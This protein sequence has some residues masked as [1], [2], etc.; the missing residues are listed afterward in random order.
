MAKYLRKY[1]KETN[2]WEVLSPSSSSDVYVTNPSIVSADTPQNLDSVL[3]NINNDIIKLKRNVS[4]LAEHGGG[5]NGI[6]GGSVASYKFLVTNGG[7]VND[8]LYVSSLPLTIKFKVSG[9]SP[10]DLVSYQVYYDG[11]SLTNGLK[12]VN[13]N[14]EQS[15]VINKFTDGI[16]NHTLRFEGIDANGMSIDTYVLTIIESS[17]KIELANDVFNY[18]INDAGD[19]IVYVTNKIINSDTRLSITNLTHNKTKVFTFKTQDTIKEAFTF[20]LFN[21]NNDDERLLIKNN[22]EVNKKYTFAISATTTTITNTEISSDILYPE[23]WFKSSNAFTIVVKGI[24]SYEDVLNNISV[25]SEHEL[26]SNLSFSFNIYHG[27]LSIAY[28]SIV[29]SKSSG[30]TRMDGDLNIYGDYYANNEEELKNSI[31]GGEPTV[32]STGVSTLIQQKIPNDSSYKGEQFIKIKCWS[33]DFKVSSS[34]IGVIDIVDSNLDIFP[35]QKPFRRVENES[36]YT[37]F[38]DFD[39]F[40]SVESGMPPSDSSSKIWRTVQYNYVGHKLDEYGNTSLQKWSP[41]TILRLVN[42]NG[43][44]SGFVNRGGVKLMR[45]QGESYGYIESPFKGTSGMKLILPHHSFTLS[46]GFKTDIHPTKDMTVFEWCSYG[47]DNNITQGIKITLEEIIWNV[48]SNKSGQSNTSVL[49]VNIQQNTLTCVDFVYNASSS[50]F[51]DK[52]IAKILVNGVVNAAV[53]IGDI[54]CDFVKNNDIYIAAS[55]IDGKIQNHSDVDIYSIRFFT[56]PLNDIDLLINSH[57]TI[58]ERTSEGVINGEKYNSWI[59]K[60]FLYKDKNSGMP[61]SDL[62]DSSGRGYKTTSFN[63]LCN[64]N[65]PLPLVYIDA[66][67]SQ[68]LSEYSFNKDFFFK[69][70][71]DSTITSHTFT[72]CTMYY[73]DKSAKN[74]VVEVNNVAISLQGTSSTI[75]R[76]K[77]LEIYFQE[78]CSSYGDGRVQLFQPKD[79]WFP[80]SQFTLKADVVDSAHA[81]NA[82]LGKWINDLSSNGILEKTVGYEINEKNPPKDKVYVNGQIIDKNEG[83]PNIWPSQTKQKVKNTL[84]GFPILLFIRFKGEQFEE[85]IGIYSFNLGRYS[86]YNLGLKFFKYFSRRKISISDSNKYEDVKCP[87][88]VKYYDFYT[89]EEVIELNNQTFY[90]RQA[91]SFEFGAGADDNTSEHST[92]SQD[93]YSILSNVGSFRYYAASDVPTQSPDPSDLNGWKNLKSL[94]TIT[95]QC[96]PQ[97]KRYTLNGDKYIPELDVNGEHMF[98]PDGQDQGYQKLVKNL[99]IHNSMVYFTVCSIFGMV[100]SLGKN[101]TLRSWNCDPSN[102]DDTVWYPCFYDMD[103][104]LGL[105]N[106]GEEI[107]EYDAYVDWYKNKP[108]VYDEQGKPNDLNTLNISPNYSGNDYQNRYGG[109]N[110]K[111]WRILRKKNESSINLPWDN[112]QANVLGSQFRQRAGYV[113]DYYEEIYS[114]LRSKDGL[115]GDADKFIE[116]FTGQTSECGEIVFNFDYSVKYLTKFASYSGVTSM[117]DIKMLH[118]NRKEYVRNW[119]NN[120]LMFLDGVFEANSYGIS[121]TPIAQVGA[122]TFGGNESISSKPIFNLRVTNPTMLI[123]SVGSTESKRY[124]L[125]PYTDVDIVFPETTSTKQATINSTSIISKF[126]GLKNYRLNKF[127]N[128]TL[129]KLTSIDFSNVQTFY[130]GTPVV[131]HTAFTFDS[132]LKD[133]EGRILYT[134]NVKEI[135]L[136]NAKQVSGGD[137]NDG[138]GTFNIELQT[139][140]ESELGKIYYNFDKVKKIDISN[141]CVSQLTLPSAILEELNIKYSDLTVLKMENQPL[142]SN[143]D[144]TGCKKLEEVYITN[145][146]NIKS[147]S[148]CNLNDLNKVNILSCSE[149]EKLYISGNSKISTIEIDKCNKLTEIVLDKNT[150]NNLEVKILSCNKLIKFSAKN[151]RTS[152]KLILPLEVNELTTFDIYGWQGIQEIQYGSNSAKKY[153]LFDSDGGTHSEHVDSSKSFKVLDLSPMT[154]ITSF[155]VSSSTKFYGSL[156]TSYLDVRE[157]TD[158]QCIKFRNDPIKPF[159]CNRAKGFSGCINLRRVFGHIVLNCNQDFYGLSEFRI[160]SDEISN[161]KIIEGVTQHDRGNFRKFNDT[162]S[163]NFG[164]VTNLRLTNMFTTTLNNIFYKTSCSLYDAY[165]L[166]YKCNTSGNIIINGQGEEYIL[167]DKVN[168][169]IKQDSISFTSISYVFQNCHNIEFTNVN[170]LSRYVYENCNVNGGSFNNPFFECKGYN[171]ILY[172]SQ[173][174]NEIGTLTIPINGAKTL[175]VIN[176]VVDKNVFYINSTT[177]SSIMSISDSNLKY[178]SSAID[179]TSDYLEKVGE[180]FINSSDI[181]KD[182]PNITNITLSFRGCRIN[183]NL[184]KINGEL[185]T[186]VISATTLFKGLVNL[187]SISDSFTNIITPNGCQIRHIFGN[188]VFDNYPSKITKIVNS[189]TFNTSG[190]MLLIGDNFFGKNRN[191]LVTYSNSFTNIDKYIFTE[192]VQEGLDF[193]YKIFDGCYNLEVV[194][195]LFKG[196]NSVTRINITIPNYIELGVEKSMF[197][198]CKKL[199]DISYLFY[200]LGNKKNVENSISYTLNGFGFTNCNLQKVDYCFGYSENKYGNDISGRKGPIPYGLF[201]KNEVKKYGQLKGL[202]KETADRLGLSEGYGIINPRFDVNN[203]NKVIKEPLFDDSQKNEFGLSLVISG[204][205]VAD[206]VSKYNITNKYTNE[207]MSSMTFVYKTDEYGLIQDGIGFDEVFENELKGIDSSNFEIFNKT[208]NSHTSNIISMEG[209][210]QYNDN[211]DLECYSINDNIKEELLIVDNENYNTIYLL[212]NSNYNPIMYNKVWDNIRLTYEF[213]YNTNYDPRRY[214]LNEKYNPYLKKAN[215]YYHDGVT[216]CSSYFEKYANDVDPSTIYAFN[217]NNTNTPQKEEFLHSEL[218]N[219]TNIN[220]RNYAFAPDLLCYCKN[221]TSLNIKKLFYGSGGPKISTWDS[222]ESN[223]LDYI[224]YGIRGTIPSFM[225]DKLSKLENVNYVFYGCTTLMPDSW[226]IL[227]END[228]IDGNILP[229]KLF[230]NNKGLKQ[231]IGTF[232]RMVYY[233]GTYL[234]D[235]TFK[236]ISNLED[237]T[238]CFSETAWLGTINTNFNGSPINPSYGNVLVQNDQLKGL[239]FKYL[240]NLKNINYMFNGNISNNGRA[241]LSDLWLLNLDLF[242][243]NKNL[244]YAKNVFNLCRSI[245]SVNNNAQLIQFANKNIYPKM[246]DCSRCYSGCDELSKELKENNITL[247]NEYQKYF[248]VS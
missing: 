50:D 247:W 141:S 8:I 55:N 186:D 102:V 39:V 214:V 34:F 150:N 182:L 195:D 164:C 121:H 218:I 20:N 237:M 189:F 205:T 67:Q 203:V 216:D 17:I 15:V 57:D 142:L 37:C 194:K 80:E 219:M 199:Y 100:D 178:I 223:K 16:S 85:L 236:T 167:Y 179:Y 95:S 191:S 165:Y 38:F 4:W 202:T 6:G 197:K 22:I 111:L 122:F 51:S 146:N 26:N 172:Y 213:V 211:I 24:N 168:E 63:I 210:F 187:T 139:E 212:E 93:D 231:M 158:I 153:T 76:V 115:L 233:P 161:S 134:S 14:T 166:L 144:V 69:S 88:V 68:S 28:Y 145:C 11:T 66:E 132:G 98:H 45:F 238:E 152:K 36:G 90:P 151:L 61:V 175:S 9:G 154:K 160:H 21:G 81:N 155:A 193:P 33:T 229:K 220:I 130:Q 2:K 181:F 112:S 75:Y 106:E 225:F 200:D 10:K 1:N 58:A 162:T 123:A 77:N 107:V 127:G 32:L 143:I 108:I 171:N 196:L 131:F 18:D 25:K 239:P 128:L 7:I 248:T 44:Q 30:E 118:G 207:V 125:P 135:N 215:K 244:Q 228:L 54:N 217:Y 174:G 104:A 232:S 113:G 129:P 156:L 65:P 133:N 82:V 13:A 40:S 206:G 86:F 99:H 201:Y 83:E 185:D 242:V 12:E 163:E 184:E 29:M 101:L 226:G 5:G 140:S 48:T 204:N 192:D 120:R 116:L 31:E 170:N 126:D 138:K 73:Y 169:D 79:E 243:D 84:E 103:T 91:V 97:S 230:E 224:N 62:Y 136:A 64:N 124:Y 70:Y 35:I 52:G 27:G 148:F 241:I 47:S 245:V 190:N 78:E 147:L 92:W 87:A 42:T 49:K 96:Y 60:N 173:K 240:K 94:F 53:E 246:I 89:K 43:L 46:V 56:Y 59:K 109:Y 180:Y 149:L 114:K 221:E 159:I 208:Y 188:G 137:G 157:C 119:L 183:F 72:N 23:I 209:C 19:F 71:N 227:T 3:T 198:D 176:G 177:K 41:E 105:T 222:S 234:S 74:E 235:E 110:S 117:G